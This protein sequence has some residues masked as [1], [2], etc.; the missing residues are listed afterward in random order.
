MRL[1]RQLERL[2]EAA[3][4]LSAAVLP[5]AIAFTWTGFDERVDLAAA[6]AGEFVAVD[7]TLALQ[8]AAG[9]D[10]LARPK[11]GAQQVTFY[12]ASY[13][14]R[15]TTDARDLGQ[16]RSKRACVAIGEVVAIDGDLVTWT[17][18]DGAAEVLR[19]ELAAAEAEAE[20]LLAEK[21]AAAKRLAQHTPAGE[22]LDEADGHGKG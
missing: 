20:Q 17:L 8:L 15:F 12:E 14:E 13:V 22:G 19:A 10:E 2:E 5:A 21:R 1:G 6:A 11:R 7:V 9:A 16:V 3:A 4:D 18:A